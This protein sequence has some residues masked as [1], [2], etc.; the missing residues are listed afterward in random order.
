MCQS[1]YTGLIVALLLHVDAGEAFG[2]DIGVQSARCVTLVSLVC[3]C[4]SPISPR[5]F[6]GIYGIPPGPSSS[7]SMTSPPGSS[8]VSCSMSVTSPTTSHP[9]VLPIIV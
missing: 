6:F 2:T 5:L 1:N 9:F 8:S 3:F 7:L 4:V